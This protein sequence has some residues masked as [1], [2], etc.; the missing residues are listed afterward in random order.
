MERASASPRLLQYPFARQGPIHEKRKSGGQGHC[1][2]RAAG[3]AG[4][5]RSSA[6]ALGDQGGDAIDELRGRLTNTIADVKKELG[7]S[8]VASAREKIAQ[9]RDTVTSVNEFVT[10]KPWTAVAIGAGVGLA[11]WIAAQRLTWSRRLTKTRRRAVTPGLRRP[12]SN[13][14]HAGTKMRRPSWRTSSMGVRYRVLRLSALRASLAGRY[15]TSHRQTT[16]A[17]DPQTARPALDRAAL[18]SPYS[19]SAPASQITP[20]LPVDDAGPGGWS[21]HRADT[22]Q[23]P[24][25]AELQWPTRR[26][27]SS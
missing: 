11:G 8:F 27:L 20:A 6:A 19:H 15:S 7:S 25:P 9:A 1:S 4:Q 26:L 3:S 13:E 22:R 10:E 16:A 5:H 2:E 24:A 23:A 18:Q 12:S 14:P 17:R 21:A